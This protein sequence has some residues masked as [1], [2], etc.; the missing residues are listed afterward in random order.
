MSAR[1]A[2]GLVIT[3]EQ[4]YQPVAADILTGLETHADLTI[5][6]G[7]G[8]SGV[9][10]SWNHNP[11]AVSGRLAGREPGPG[12]PLRAAERHDVQPRPA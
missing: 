12:D 9:P 5:S 3:L 10:K 6:S 8:C 11:A 1:G 4:D 2:S 7:S